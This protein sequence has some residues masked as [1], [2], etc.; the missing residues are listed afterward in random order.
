[1]SLRTF[2][3]AYS[4][5]RN[6]TS[7]TQQ[8][9]TVRTMA[10]GSRVQ[11]K[12]GEWPEYYLPGITQEQASK[13]SALLQTNHEQHHIFF[14]QSG[15][16]N[17]IAHHLLTVYA[18]AASPSQIQQHYDHNVGYQRPPQPLE[19]NI[20]DDMRDP[21]H[22]QKYLGNERYY[23]D[24]LSFFQA[25]MAEKGWENVINEY[26]FAGDERAEAMLVRM[27]AGKKT[28]RSLHQ[29]K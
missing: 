8:L 13:T 2:R 28:L 19:Q 6:I 16:H 25:E 9:Q 26:V 4:L 15:F 23:S 27:F 17:H 1:M 21:K 20:V 11:L 22:F 5:S 12:L 7:P 14:N 18:L 24:Y 10:T 3:S 29:D